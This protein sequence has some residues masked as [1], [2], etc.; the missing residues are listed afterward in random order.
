MSNHISKPPVEVSNRA[1][2]DPDE[3]EQLE[4]TSPLR[5]SLIPVVH[6][7]SEMNT[8]DTGVHLLSELGIEGIDKHDEQDSS[9][10]KDEKKLDTKSEADAKKQAAKDNSTIL[11]VEDTVELAEVIQATIE[12]MGFKAVFE[13]HG[14]AGIERLKEL[15]PKLMLMDIGLPDISGWKMLDMIKEAY[16]DNEAAIPTIIVITAYGDP[17]NRLIGKLQ[18][19]YSYLLKPFTPDEVERLVNMALRGEKP[20]Q[21][22]LGDETSST[23]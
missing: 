14:K 5:T 20:P 1:E 23:K 10:T 19:I 7:T 15:K 8:S 6:D 12:G 9:L 22:N 2:G 18:N 3:R 16:V 17:A 21:A 11:I 13:T 4:P